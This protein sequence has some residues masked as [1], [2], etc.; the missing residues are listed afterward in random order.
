MIYLTSDIHNDINHKGLKKYISTA[1]SGDLLIILGDVG[2]NFPEKDNYIEFEDFFLSQKCNIAFLDGNHENREYINSFPKESWNGGQ[3]HRL[4]DSIV[5]LMRGHIF[6]ISG[7]TFFVMGGC[8][9]SQKWWDKG[10][11][12]KDDEPSADEIIFGYENLSKY[13]NTVDYV[14]TH[15]YN[16]IRVPCDEMNSLGGML[17][18]LDDNISFKAWYCGHWHINKKVDDKHFIVYDDLIPLKD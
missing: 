3:V 1:K 17:G 6:D 15:N 11:A 16:E 4:T 18:F 14:L 5:H 7:S 10:L 8:K 2:L 12:Y 9:S 13:N